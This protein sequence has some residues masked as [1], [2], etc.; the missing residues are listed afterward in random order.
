MMRTLLIAILLLLI[1]AGIL[2]TWLWATYNALVR[3]RNE[4]Q[5]AWGQVET[6]T[7]RRLD[8]VPALVN[9]VQ[10]YASH[11]RETLEGVIQAR[12]Q[13]AAAGPSAEGDASQDFLSSALGK[14]FA[15]QEAYPNLKADQNFQDL[16]NQLSNV[17]RQINLA[18]R[19]YNE[20]VKIYNTKQQEF[21]ANLVAKRFGHNE[22]QLF[23]AKAGADEPPTVSFGTR[24]GGV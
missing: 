13:A 9:T 6:E 3:V 22:A 23:A 20:Q 16:Q 7:Q 11:E 17:E 18:R 1:V 19:I 21:P 14:L 24:T 4:A 2:G 10:G 15:L 5:T 12:A 8:L